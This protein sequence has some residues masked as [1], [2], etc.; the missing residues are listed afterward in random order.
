FPEKLHSDQ[1]RNFESKVIQELCK[2]LG[3]K[4]TRTTPYHPMGNGSAERFNQ[5]LIKMLSTLNEK[6]KSDWKSHVAP[7]VQA[8]NATRNDATGYTPHYLM[9]GWHPKLPIDVFFGMD[10]EHE[11]GDHHGYVEKLKD[12]MVSAYRHASQEARRISDKNKNKYDQ[13]VRFCKLEIGDRV[14]VRKVGLKGKNKL[15][16][17]WDSEVYVITEIPNPEIPVFRVK[18]TSGRATK[19]LHRNMLLPFNQIPACDIDEPVVYR[20]PVTRR[21]KKPKNSDELPES[22][23][24]SSDDEVTIEVKSR[25]PRNRDEFS[26][27]S[28][29]QHSVSRSKVSSVSDGTN[30]NISSF[31]NSSPS[32]QSVSSPRQSGYTSES[33]SS[34]T[35]A[36]VSGPHSQFISDQSQSPLPILPRR[37][38]RMKKFPDRYGEWI[39]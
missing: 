15:A 32:F 26:K 1:G 39:M 11:K 25:I 16:D 23:S 24:E 33:D 18:S 36:S 17:R 2:L 14:L 31:Q 3:I 30:Q 12:R 20:T 34:S 9:F 29:D 19:T 37:S 27:E 4:K 6:Q 7:L 38:T 21:N 8:Y 22:D 5:T 13:R 35:R 28:S 10:L